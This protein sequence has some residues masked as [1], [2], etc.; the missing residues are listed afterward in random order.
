[1]PEL[2]RMP[3]VATNTTEA[4]LLSWPVAENIPFVKR[5]TIATVETAKAVVDVEAEA[6]GVILRT[7]VAEGA[8]V[9]VGEPIALIGRSDEQ[10]RDID[11]ALAEL[12]H[13]VDDAKG[14]RALDIPE[15]DPTPSAPAP[16]AV[17]TSA[18]YSRSSRPPAAQGDSTRTFASPLARRMAREAG[19]PLSEMNGTGP[20]QRVLR[21]DVQVAIERHLNVAELPAT[22]EP[23][24]TSP[25]PT[26]PVPISSG[27]VPLGSDPVSAN[28]PAFTD[29]PL[30]RS[31]RM[32]ASRL[33]ESKQTIPHFYLRASAR[34]DPL[35]ALRAELNH[36]GGR[37]VRISVNDL[38]VKAVAGAHQQVAALN[39]TWADTAIRHYADVDIA[40]A[41]ATEVGLVTPVIRATQRSTVTEIAFAAQGYANRARL[42]QLRQAELEGG[43]TTVTNLGMFGV[44]EFAAI[45]NPPQAS[46]LAVGAARPQ[47][48]VRKGKVRIATMMALTLSV[49]HRCVDGAEAAE[50]MAAL[51]HL[52]EHPLSIL[53]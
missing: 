18:A 24:S 23:A 2:L 13:T 14:P 40:I 32:I 20:N 19:L 33:S 28:D 6:D 22:P 46:I 11:Q 31:R 27:P 12:G 30:S 3:E 41:V 35:L 1:M 29:Q 15:A 51:V 10:V 52:L 39:V 50:W 38:V 49:D 21:R 53:A 44:E 25:A 5:D 9:A 7:L 34:L 36:V 37:S 4:V 43:S 16:A 45:I 47:P 42:G 17:A 48:H 8:E 26:S